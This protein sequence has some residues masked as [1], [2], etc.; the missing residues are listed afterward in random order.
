MAI[1]PGQLNRWVYTFTTGTEEVWAE[2]QERANEILLERSVLTA[3]DKNAEVV[4]FSPAFCI[5]RTKGPL[6]SYTNQPAGSSGFYVSATGNSGN[7]GTQASPWDLATALS[8]ASG[9]IQ[10]GDTV[11]LRGGTYSGNF[12]SSLVG[13]ANSPILVQS[14]PGERPIISG[15]FKA[16]IGSAYGWYKGFEVTDAGLGFNGCESY[17]NY[18]RL[19]NVIVHDCQETGL[20]FWNNG[21]SGDI[22]GCIS[23]NNGTH[24]NLDHG[25]Y[26]QNSTGLKSVID[27][28]FNNNMAYGIQLYATS[29][30]LQHF[31]LRGNVSYMNG[32]LAAVAQRR[33]LFIGALN[34]T[35]DDITLDQN[36]TYFPLATQVDKGVEVGYDVTANG[37]LVLTD[38]YFVGGVHVLY[39]SN[40]A[41]ASVLRNTLVGGSGAQLYELVNGG[42]VSQTG[43]TFANNVTY[44][45]AANT[46]WNHNNF[47]AWHAGALGATDTNPGTVPTAAKVFI[48]PN[49]YETGRGHVVI[50]NWASLSTVQVDLSSILSIGNAYNVYNMENLFGAPVLTGTYNGGTVGFPMS[51]VAPAVLHNVVPG[52]PIATGPTF[53]VFL[54]RLQGA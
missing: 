3:T 12:T 29:G 33:N 18:N 44:N 8:G 50:Y 30:G 14:Y 22:Y 37:S 41:S 35:P 13:T 6:L 2:N 15:N 5:H 25:A 42:A 34:I 51:A 23:Y 24:D 43:W 46:A 38:N 45:A 28:V 40:W 4:G 21:I 11:W 52:T 49:L 32:S 27:C 20:G 16:L 48:R 17:G 7:N 31:L 1:V 19:I 36:M 47:A 54:V 10:P 53:Q 39:Q 26:A 9:K